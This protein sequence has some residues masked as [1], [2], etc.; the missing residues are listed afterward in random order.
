MTRR[1][2]LWFRGNP[3]VSAPASYPELPWEQ[4]RRDHVVDREVGCFRWSGCL[5]VAV[6]G[7]LAPS[8]R[9]VFGVEAGVPVLAG[10]PGSFV[11]VVSWLWSGRGRSP[12]VT[13]G[14]VVGAEG[15][16]DGFR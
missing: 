7:I 6:C 1:R 15:V 3:Q 16:C 5:W 13:D 10:L 9:R 2:Q 8:T 12:A 4:L 14:P 11:A